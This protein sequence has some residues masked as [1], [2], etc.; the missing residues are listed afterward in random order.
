MDEGVK[1]RPPTVQ[2]QLRS[3]RQM[4][5]EEAQNC[6]KTET[7]LREQ[8]AHARANT[9]IAVNVC[10]DVGCDFE[11]LAKQLGR[12]SSTLRNWIRPPKPETEDTQA[13]SI[14]KAVAG[15]LKGE[16]HDG[17]DD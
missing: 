5:T 11:E 14:A 16:P 7:K 2:E 6:I 13:E 8:M 4:A 1:D 9:I 12:S 10:A 15:T 3:L 17:D